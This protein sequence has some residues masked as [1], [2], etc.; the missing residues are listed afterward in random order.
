MQNY[1]AQAQIQPGM[2]PTEPLKRSGFLNDRT[3]Y[4]LVRMVWQVLP[5][6]RSCKWPCNL[7]KEGIGHHTVW[8]AGIAVAVVPPNQCQHDHMIC[9]PVCK[10]WQVLPVSGAIMPWLQSH[11]SP[12]VR[13]SVR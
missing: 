9:L 12:G 13:H 6:R 8:A 5:S 10:D 2:L 7:N 3:V 11:A 1:A 4:P